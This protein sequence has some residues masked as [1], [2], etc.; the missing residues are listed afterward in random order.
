MG[1]VPEVKTNGTSAKASEYRMH[2]QLASIPL[3][4][5]YTRELSNGYLNESRGS[6]STEQ[7][8][9]R[10]ISSQEMQGKI[11][12]RMK[13]KEM[14]DFIESDEESDNGS[15]EY[16]YESEVETE[17]L[18]YHESEWTDNKVPRSQWTEKKV[19]SKWY[20]FYNHGDGTLDFLTPDN[21]YPSCPISK[22]INILGT[23][24]FP[25]QASLQTPRGNNSLHFAAAN[26]LAKT[27]GER[28]SGSS[29]AS[30]TW[31]HHKD[32]GRMQLLNRQVHAAFKHCGGKA[33]WGTS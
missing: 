31:H 26:Q 27:K 20:K 21:G 11:V 4:S 28:G 25:T 6:E 14:D 8:S 9:P 33:I 18:E 24:K 29:P 10:V 17:Y 2:T 30:W 5:S 13:R 19:G 3:L 32:A 12:Q 16:N 15:E 22:D 1:I 7:I 23:P